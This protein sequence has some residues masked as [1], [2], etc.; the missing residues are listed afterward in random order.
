MMIKNYGLDP[1]ATLF[2]LDEQS[3]TRE[4]SLLN[5]AFEYK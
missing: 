4:K 5:Y 3:I 2:L 1:N